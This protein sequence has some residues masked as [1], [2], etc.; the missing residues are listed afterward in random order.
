VATE[1]IDGYLAALADPTRGTLEALRRSI[2]EAVLQAE[3]GIS[4]GMPRSSSR[5]RRWPA[6]RRRRVRFGSP[7]TSRCPR[8]WWRS[9]SSR[10]CASSGWL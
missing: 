3:Q 2:L 4:Y 8:C 6:T 9:S 5:A 1:E 7:S 10:A